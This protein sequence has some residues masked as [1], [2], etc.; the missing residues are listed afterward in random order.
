[1]LGVE[2]VHPGESFAAGSLE[3]CECNAAYLVGRPVRHLGRAGELDIGLGQVLGLEVVEVVTLDDL[4]LPDLAGPGGSA[5]AT[6][7][8]AA[9]DLAPDDGGLD[10]DLGV[11]LAAGER[12]AGR[13][14]AGARRR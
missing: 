14:A 13:R 8:H 12:E 3:R 5:A 11:V 4:D 6:L 2:A 9:L 7:Q 10:D 1:M